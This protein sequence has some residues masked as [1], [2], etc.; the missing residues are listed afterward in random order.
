MFNNSALI[1]CVCLY[2][3]DSDHVPIGDILAPD[4]K[5]RN[6]D[7]DVVL[8]VDKVNKMNSTFAGTYGII[9]ADETA[10]FPFRGEFDPQGIT[11]GW[12]VS[13]WNQEENDHALGAWAGYARLSPDRIPNWII[14]TTRIIAHEDNYNT[15]TGYDTFVLE[16]K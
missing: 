10:E 2:I 13:Y 16:S 1:L 11:V 6:Y 8:K 15:T 9:R 4:Q 7:D 14:S 3:F 5:W 12:V